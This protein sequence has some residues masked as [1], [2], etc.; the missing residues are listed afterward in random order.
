[1]KILKF[2]FSILLF[3][4]FWILAS[5]LYLA[6]LILT[7]LGDFVDLLRL[8]LFIKIGRVFYRNSPDFMDNR[9][10]RTFSYILSGIGWFYSLIP[11]FLNLIFSLCYK[12]T[13]IGIEMMKSLKMK[14][15]I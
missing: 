15:T 12:A 14:D 7:K 3:S 4:V 6:A 8:G 11:K 1:M 9:G 5:V 2:I 10:L 13:R